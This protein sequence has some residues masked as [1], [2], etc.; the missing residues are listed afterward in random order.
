MGLTRAWQSTPYGRHILLAIVVA[1]AASALAGALNGA[2]V[3]TTRI[4]PFIVTL[5]SMIG[6]RGLAKWL[7][8]NPN[9]DI[10]FGRDVA[11]DFAAVFRQKTIAIGAYAVC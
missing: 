3:A 1:V 6:V 5:A 10:G 8:D 7:T 11:A 2:I 4:Q 9:I